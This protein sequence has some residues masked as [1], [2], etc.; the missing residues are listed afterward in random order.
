VAF[1]GYGNT[2]SRPGVLESD[3][4]SLRR[5][6]DGFFLKLAYQFRN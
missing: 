2:M 5:E 6:S 4:N 1:F 3:S